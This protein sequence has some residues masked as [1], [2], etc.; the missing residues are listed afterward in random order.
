MTPTDLE[1]YSADVTFNKSIHEACGVF[2]MILDRTAPLGQMIF[3]GLYALQHRGQESCGMGVFDHDQL[4]LHKDMGLVNQ[5]FTPRIIDKMTGQVGVGHTRYSTTGGSSL[6]NAQPVVARSPYGA[7]IMA[8]NGNLTN[9]ESLRAFVE[10]EGFHCRGDSDSHVMVQLINYELHQSSD[11]RQYDLG[12]AVV[13]ALNRCE[14]AFSLV[15]ATGDTLIAARDRHALR[16]LS[17]GELPTGGIVFASETCA[18]DIVGA[19]YLRDIEPGEVFFTNLTGERQS[20]YLDGEKKNH[21]CVFELVYFARPDSKIKDAS[22]YTYRM[23]LGRRLAQIAPPVYADFVIPVPDSGNVAAVG[24][25]QASGVPYAEGLI[26]NRYV[27]R[28][29]IHPT[30]ELREQ[31]IQLKLNP[32]TDI[33]QGKRIIIV[34]DSIV[35]GNTSKKLVTMLKNAGVIEIHLRISSAPV[36]HPCY[37][38]IDM[39]QTEELIANR[40]TQEELVEWLGVDSLVY[41]SVEDMVSIARNNAVCTACFSGEYPAGEIEAG[42]QEIVPQEIT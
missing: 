8:H 29:F 3:Y 5:V 13:R 31:G 9:T 38:G 18:L 23:A 25:S 6:E 27:G 28:T 11:V 12:R 19:Q 15:I 40:M 37:Y 35:R 34:D 16:P 39:S 4:F 33:L 22:V 21:F 10:A 36:R 41:L 24:Y 30:Q 42:P 17:V 7:I 1:E 2:G 32:L 26:K 14:G 20:F